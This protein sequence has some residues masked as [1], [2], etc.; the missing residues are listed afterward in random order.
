MGNAPKTS[1][2]SEKNNEH[3]RKTGATITKQHIDFKQ[4]LRLTDKKHFQLKEKYTLATVQGF[5]C[6]KKNELL[7]PAHTDR[8]AAM[9]EQKPLNIRRLNTQKADMHQGAIPHNRG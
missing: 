1:E 9:T 5:S 4:N 2:S 3:T 8:D 6:K 7:S